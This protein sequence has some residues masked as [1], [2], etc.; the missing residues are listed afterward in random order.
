MLKLE[1]VSKVYR[2]EAVETAALDDDGLLAKPIGNVF[3]RL[4]RVHAEEDLRDVGQK[5]LILSFG[6]AFFQLGETLIEE[7]QAAT[8]AAILVHRVVELLQMA[9]ARGFIQNKMHQLALLKPTPDHR[10]QH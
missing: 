4:R 10:S 3:R 5:I 8:I 6:E 7:H 2:A 9:E 1:H